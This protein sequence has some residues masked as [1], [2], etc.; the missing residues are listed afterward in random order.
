MYP[1]AKQVALLT[2]VLLKRSDKTRARV[3]EKTIKNLAGRTTLRT[4]FVADLRKWLEDFGVLLVQ[5]DRGG[6]ALT[7][8]ASLEGAPTILS[9]NY[10]L[11]ERRALIAGSLGEDKLLD[12]LGITGEEAED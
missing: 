11:E 7:S 5:L 2:A 10:V 9:K 4:A 1:S 12:E 3:S 6:F 8:I